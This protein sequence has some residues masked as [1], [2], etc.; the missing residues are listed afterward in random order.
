MEDRRDKDYKV[1]RGGWKTVEAKAREMGWKK[2]KKEEKKE[3]E[4]RK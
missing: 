2:Q 1:P 3:K 4:E